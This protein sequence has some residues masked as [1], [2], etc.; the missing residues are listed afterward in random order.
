VT[1]VD[2]L[3]AGVRRRERLA[4]AA[5]GLARFALPAGL[6]IAAISIFAIRIVGVG[7][8]VLWLT[9]APVPVILAWAFLR[10]RS[11]R[12][13]A[14]KVDTHYGLDDEIGAAYELQRSPPRSMGNDE[15]RT[16]EIVALLQAQAEARASSLGAR[17]VVDVRV[18]PPG[19]LDAV[20]LGLVAIAAILPEPR[21]AWME[22]WFDFPVREMAEVARAREGLDLALADPLRQNLRGLAKGQDEVAQTAQRIL[23]ILDELGAGELDRAE[24]FDKLEELEALL[25][26][27]EKALEEDLEEDP[28]MLA[29]AVNELADGL[30][31]HEVTED[32]GKHFDENRPEEAEDALND[33]GEQA[34]Q[35]SKE[36]QEA[37][38]KAMEEAERR[39][40]KAAKQQTETDKEL[41]EAERR[42]RKEEKR[43]TKDPE[44]KERRL[45]QMREQVEKLRRQQQ[46]EQAAQRKLEE[47]KRNAKDAADKG[48]SGQ[49]RKRS[50]EKLSRGAK[51]AA[52]QGRKSSRTKQLRDSL[53]EAKT[54]VRQAGKQG[55]SAKRRQQQFK[56]FS[57][58]AKGKQGKDGK[59]GK[60][61]GKSTLLVEGKVGEGEPN[62]MME[63]DSQGE[64]EGES[65]SQGEG[66]SDSQG[67]GEGE[68][69]GDS[70]GEGQDSGDGQNPGGDG[71]GEGSVDPLGN[72]MGLDAKKKNVH[73]K[74]KPGKGV[75]RA[76]VIRD[77][78]QK[79]FATES[80]RKVYTDYRGHAQSAIDNEAL[81]PAKRRAVKRYYQYIQ[82]RN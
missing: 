53:E 43:E 19:W 20:A 10:P 40:D 34:E 47:L 71:I 37:M 30:Q 7:P 52:Q 54:F 77:S 3:L 58:A 31:E 2:R 79:G 69:E 38:R 61:K 44:E 28:G 80:Y 8:M 11:M 56:K 68:S 72:P 59:D 81:P 55:D 64:G 18:P 51:Q 9:A 26:E 45:K 14:R 67:E 50:L 60:G 66:E 48:K 73:V 62:M 76:E 1:A 12:A 49:D 39:L 63:G 17:G 24:A 21:S 32:A 82:P 42:L 33:A 5:R 41:D 46:R 74:A 78:S 75:S 65:D 25:T 36:D 35:G 29:D 23:E 70:Q 6:F 15:Q 4:D 13:T 27:V 22:R 57:Q 16:R